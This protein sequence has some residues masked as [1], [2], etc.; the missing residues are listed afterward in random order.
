MKVI[1]DTNILVRA[2]VRDHEKQANAADKILRTATSI[3][4]SPP[5]LCEFAWVLQRLYHFDAMSVAQAIRA[6]LE[7]EKVVMNRPAVEA[8]LAI[9]EAGGDFAD[10]VMAYEGSWLG[11]EI[12][13][14]FDKKA[15]EL[16]AA[17][18]QSVHVPG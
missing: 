15:T 5:C 18:G 9:L 11:G 8:G 1:A 4:V 13:V 3:A 12:F 17:Q 14:S 16:L 7:T 10:G 6:L 2:V